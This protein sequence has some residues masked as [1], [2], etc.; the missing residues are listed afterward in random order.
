MVNNDDNVVFPGTRSTQPLALRS[1]CPGFLAFLGPHAQD[2]L[3]TVSPSDIRQFRDYQ[4]DLG[5]LFLAFAFSWLFSLAF[6][7]HS[8]WFPKSLKAFASKGGPILDLYQH[9]AARDKFCPPENPEKRKVSLKNDHIGEIR[10]KL[11]VG[12]FP[13][14]AVKGHSAVP[15]TDPHL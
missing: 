1:H 11:G 8:F 15:R 6:L 7:F 5:Y 9:K 12:Q 4:A 13:F 2:D 3:S 10:A 14:G